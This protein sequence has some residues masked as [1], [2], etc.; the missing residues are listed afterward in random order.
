MALARVLSSAIALVLFESASAAAVEWPQFR[1]PLGDGRV[2]KPGFP[3]RWS[4]SENVA[5]KVKIPGEGWSQPV[6]WGDKVFLTAAV[7]D[8]APKPKGMSEGTQAPSSIFPGLSKPVDALYRWEVVCVNL[9]NGNTLWRRQVAEKKP[10]IAKHPSNTYATET[11]AT[12]GERVYAWFGSIGQVA[13]V[14]FSG[15]LLWKVDLGELPSMGGLGTGSSP[16]VRDGLVYVQCY[17]QPAS[18]LLALDAKTGKE[19][20]RAER[21]KGGS[22]STPYIWTNKQ[23]TELIACGDSKVIA[24]DPATGKPLWEIGGITSSFTASPAATAESLFL[25]NNGPFSTAPL[26]AVKAGASGDITLGKGEKSND[27]VAWWRLRSGPGLSSMAVIDD[28]LFVSTGQFLNCHDIKTGE[29]L[30][31]ERLAKAR[32]I[33]ASPLVLGD[34]LLLLDEDGRGYVVKAGRKFEV[35][36]TN[37]LDDIFW[38]SPAA[39]DGCLLLRGVEHLYCIQARD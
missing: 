13:A 23:R 4:E 28:L 34:K 16:V 37:K 5:W 38:A 33:V 21:S 3:L 29:R 18:F 9:E 39:A 26:F 11:P 25:G 15:E 12:D 31:R 17:T 2:A 6:V 1:G 7:S 19:V 24:Y 32:E 22:W 10:T 36:E 14:N 20:W 30:Y 8:S 27:F 35:I